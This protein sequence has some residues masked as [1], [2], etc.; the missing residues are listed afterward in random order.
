MRGERVEAYVEALLTD[1]SPMQFRA[2]LEEAHA[3]RAAIGLR[4]GGVS[5]SPGP[6]FVE[7]LHRQLVMDPDR[8][9][10]S[11]VTADWLPG[12]PV[13]IGE[14]LRPGRHRRARPGLASVGK[15]AAALLL[16][17][18]TTWAGASVHRHAPAPS[19]ARAVTTTAVRSAELRGTDG[20]PLGRTFAYKG[21][22]SWVFMDVRGGGLS[23]VYRCDLYLVNGTVVPAGEVAAY[24]GTGDWGHTVGVDVSQLQRA[25]LVTLAGE[26]VATAAFR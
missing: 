8:Q 19:A 18:G 23:G 9:D 5:V 10:V 16:V 6:Q 14:T 11:R 3:L 7:R 21:N 13:R 26:P 20:R 24:N 2:T 4:T 22:P 12:D 15:A 1:R 25:A 17:A